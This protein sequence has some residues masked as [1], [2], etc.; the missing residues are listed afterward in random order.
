MTTDRESRWLQRGGVLTVLLG[1]AGSALYLTGPAPMKA[2]P[3]IV[4]VAIGVLLYIGG[5][6]APAT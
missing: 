3:G 2:M 5:S 4:L 6:K 1:V